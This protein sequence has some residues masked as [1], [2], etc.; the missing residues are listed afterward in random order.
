MTFS[1][2][3]FSLI[4]TGTLDAFLNPSSNPNEAAL[5]RIVP[6]PMPYS[7]RRQAILRLEQMQRDLSP[8]HESA[9]TGE[10]E[11]RRIA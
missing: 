6:P 9:T 10:V 7:S 8:V 2:L 5:S 3:P 1:S 4:S 11:V